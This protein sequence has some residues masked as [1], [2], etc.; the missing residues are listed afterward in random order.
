MKGRLPRLIGPGAGL[1]AL[2]LGALAGWSF[3]PVLI[4]AG[5]ALL[6]GSIAGLW[7]TKHKEEE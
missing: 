3:A 4:G 5:C 7:I 1:L 2:T 6:A